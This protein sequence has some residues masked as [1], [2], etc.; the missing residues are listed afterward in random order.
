MVGY[1]LDH[2]GQ[3]SETRPLV[4]SSLFATGTL[5]IGTHPMPRVRRPIN[6]Y[7]GANGPNGRGLHRRGVQPKAAE[8]SI[9]PR[10]GATSSTLARD[11][12]Q[13]GATVDPRRTDATLGAYAT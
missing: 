8:L 2:D 5:R 13:D 11:V 10:K 7:G 9:I 6:P 12:P 3:V 1:R 4:L